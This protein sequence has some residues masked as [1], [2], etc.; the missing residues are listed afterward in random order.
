MGSIDTSLPAM[1]TKP[2][3]I[4]FTDFDGTITQADSNDFMTDTIG[5]G[6]EKRKAGNKAVLDGKSA[7]RDEF[8]KMMDS[9]TRPFDQCIAYLIENITLDPGFKAFFEYARK[10]NIPI[11]VLS[12]GMTPIIKALLNHLIGPEAAEIQIVSNMV[13]SR[14][15]RDINTEGGWQI[16]FHDDS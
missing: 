9:V 3:F 15:G 12:G 13:A 16:Q 5:F 1:K 7:F 4:F 11:V 2:N 14:D 8:R 10:N 6:A